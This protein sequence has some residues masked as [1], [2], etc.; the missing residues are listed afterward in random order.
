[1]N[2]LSLAGGI[3]CD[4]VAAAQALLRRGAAGGLDTADPLRQVLNHVQ[5]H[6]VLLY[7]RAEDEDAA[8]AVTAA[9]FSMRQHTMMLRLLVTHPRM[10]R[11]GFARITVHFLK[12]LCR[13]LSQTEIL[14]YTC[15]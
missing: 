7:Y 4:Q 5:S 14:V 8:I 12:E 1:M 13:A 9:T 11:K 2:H 15:G 6:T 3:T 10:T